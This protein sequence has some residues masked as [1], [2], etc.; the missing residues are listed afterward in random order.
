MTLSQVMFPMSML[1]EIL[2][3]DQIAR[4]SECYNF[5]ENEPFF[6]FSHD[7]KFLES[8]SEFDVSWFNSGL[9]ASEQLVYYTE[10]SEEQKLNYITH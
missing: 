8:C 1:H 3:T 2:T 7:D 10:L 6:H 5:D 4:Y 9:P